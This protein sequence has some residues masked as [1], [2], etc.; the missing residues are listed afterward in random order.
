MFFPEEY[1]N[2]NEEQSKTRKGCDA[3]GEDAQRSTSDLAG[4]R[5]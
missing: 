1:K 4:S 3:G 2:G 5:L